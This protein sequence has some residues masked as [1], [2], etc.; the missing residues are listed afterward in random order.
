MQLI[1]LCTYSF[2]N[3]FTHPF[4]HSL[5]PSFIHS[6][7]HSFIHSFI[8]SL[9]HSFTHSLHSFIHSVF[10]YFL[11]NVV[12]RSNFRHD[13]QE[14]LRICPIMENFIG[15]FHL[16][17]MSQGMKRIKTLFH[18]YVCFSMLNYLIFV[19]LCGIDTV[20]TAVC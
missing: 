5:I 1:Y 12:A 11:Q 15:E 16:I 7:T 6:F 20:Y 17:A 8:H 3:S 14:D 19:S 2:I 9:I 4:T 18:M 10:V 13:F